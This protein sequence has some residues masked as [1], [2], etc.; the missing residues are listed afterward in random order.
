MK[1]VIQ[2]CHNCISD[3]VKKK[4]EALFPPDIYFNVMFIDLITTFYLHYLFHISP[5]WTFTSIAHSALTFIAQ[6]A[7][8]WTVVNCEPIIFRSLIQLW[9]VIEFIC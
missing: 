4:S 8:Q 2:H 1:T 7:A 6:Q 3:I 5:L 9:L